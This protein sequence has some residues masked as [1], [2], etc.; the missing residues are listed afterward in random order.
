MQKIILGLLLICIQMPVFAAEEEEAPAEKSP[1]YIS[2]GQPLVL[3]LAED[4]LLQ[5]QAD[6]LVAD[7]DTKPDV[8]LHI[9]MIRHQLILMLSEQPPAAMKS[10]VKREEMRQKL[11][12]RVRNAYRELTGEDPIREVLFPSFLVQ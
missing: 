11:S 8:E 9:P 4:R 10:P 3:N 2:L 7:E 6:I 5:V 1:G 12:D